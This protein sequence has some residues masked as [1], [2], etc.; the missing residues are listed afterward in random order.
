MKG[1]DSY[2]KVE[3][4][5]AKATAGLEEASAP[6]EL[7]IPRV[8]FDGL[9]AG[10]GKASWSKGAK[11]NYKLGYWLGN[12]KAVSFAGSNVYDVELHATPDAI[13]SLTD[14]P[15]IWEPSITGGSRDIPQ[16]WQTIHVPGLKRDLRYSLYNRAFGDSQNGWATEPFSCTDSRGRTG[17]YR[18]IVH[19]DEEASAKAVFAKL[20]LHQ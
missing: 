17:W 20:R 13:E 18:V 8:D 11:G 2:E 9:P 12:S 5:Q 19:A 1:A 16:E 3:A 7:A 15:L 6:G 14:A 10:F 4:W